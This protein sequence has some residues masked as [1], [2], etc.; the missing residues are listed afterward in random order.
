MC[1]QK[2]FKQFIREYHPTSEFDYSEK[3]LIK[4]ENLIKDYVFSI[5]MLK[6]TNREIKQLFETLKPICYGNNMMCYIDVSH[7]VTSSNKKTL[8]FLVLTTF[9][10]TIPMHF[11]LIQGFTVVLK[12]TRQFSYHMSLLVNIN[13]YLYTFFLPDDLLFETAL[14]VFYNVNIN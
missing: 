8:C 7:P 11:V 3:V 1:H 12:D 6:I 14:H 9:Q 4:R 5:L 10:L 13:R 2:H